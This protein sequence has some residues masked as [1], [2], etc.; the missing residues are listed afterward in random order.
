[1][2]LIVGKKLEQAW[3]PRCAS[4]E[5]SDYHYPTSLQSA[6]YR[7]I[8]TPQTYATT[9]PD[10]RVARRNQFFVVWQIKRALTRARMY[11]IMDQFC[12]IDQVT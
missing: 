12:R 9:D 7:T 3:R 1:M 6:L 2:F 8:S 4:G 5:K 10:W 11:V